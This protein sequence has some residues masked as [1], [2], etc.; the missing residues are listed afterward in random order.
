MDVFGCFFVVDYKLE[1]DFFGDC[2]E[3][4]DVYVSCDFSGGKLIVGQFKQFFLLDDCISFNYGFFLECGNVGIILVLLYWL[5]V[6]WQ[7]VKGDMIWVVSVYSL[8]S[9]DIWQV[10]GCVVGGWV[11][12]VF[13][14][15]VGDVLYLGLLLVYECYDNFGVN[16]VFGLKICLCLVGYLFDNSCL[17]LVDFLVGCDIDVNKWLM[18]YVQV[19]GLL[20]WQGEFSGVIFDDG[21]QCVKVMVGYGLVSWFVIGEL[22]VYDCKIGCFVWVKDLCY[23]V[24]VFE[25]VLCYDQMCGDQYLIGQL[26]LIDVCIDVWMFGGNWYMCLN[27]CFMFNLIE[28]C[29]CDCFVDVI[30]DCI[31][32]VIG[33]LQFDF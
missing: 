8:E 15:I 11:M 22:W 27:L 30:V 9:I 24:G 18:E 26:D 12:W 31:C 16:G 13:G 23:K 32:V 17:M 7:V 33:C 6:F 2:V 19:C 29:N 3:V 10:K 20:F 28:S 14:V 1:V 25:L 21:S 4:K 5:G